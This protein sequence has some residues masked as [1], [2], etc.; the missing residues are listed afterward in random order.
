MFQYD[1][2][3][4]HERYWPISSCSFFWWR[5]CCTRNS[6]WITA[7]HPIIK[8]K[9][10]EMMY[11]LYRYDTFRNCSE[12]ETCK[13][14]SRWMC[15]C[16]SG[17]T[18]LRLRTDHSRHFSRK[19]G[20]RIAL[21]NI[22]MP[23][24]FVAKKRGDLWEWHGVKKK[25]IEPE[26]PVNVGRLCLRQLASPWRFSGVVQHTAA[27]STFGKVKWAAPASG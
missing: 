4:Y 19:K 16:V 9:Q 21:L 12:I 10:N 8:R 7:R 22:R 27:Y 2:L 20:L 25:K 24:L 18:Y 3:S 13:F 23:G 17:I 11:M 15:E 5:Q 6:T 1:S 26:V 14:H